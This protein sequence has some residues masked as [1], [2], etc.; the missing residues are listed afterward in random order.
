MTAFFAAHARAFSTANPLQSLRRSSRTGSIYGDAP[1]C[2]FKSWPA[3]KG[4]GKG[5]KEDW[6]ALIGCYQFQDE[7]KALAYPSNPIDTLEPLA[8]A[9]VAIVHVVGDADDV[10]P[11]LENTAIVETRYRKLGGK[12][13]VIH[14]PSGGHHPHGLD[15]P[16]PV[17]DFILSHTVN[18]F[19]P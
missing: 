16:T 15:N 12:I 1:V 6:A 13:K 5:S 4:K 18:Q 3:G 8:A 17:V 7:A 9:G 11:V 2:D 10:V 19:T 14:K